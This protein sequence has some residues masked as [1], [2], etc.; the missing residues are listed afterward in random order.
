MLSNFFNVS[1]IV[2][3]ILQPRDQYLTVSFC[4]IKGGYDFISGVSDE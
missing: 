4:D 2:I 3:I 1:T